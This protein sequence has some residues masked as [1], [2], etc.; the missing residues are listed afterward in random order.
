MSDLENT[1]EIQINLIKELKGIESVILMQRG[2]IPIHSSGKWFSIN[3][4]NVLSSVSSLVFNTGIKLH[5]QELKYI[6]I[7]SRY[8]KIL[9]APL[10]SPIEPFLIKNVNFHGINDH[11]HEFFILI[12]AQ[13][14]INLGGIFLQTSECLRK[15]KIHLFTSGESYREESNPKHQSLDE[16]SNYISSI[17]IPEM[18]SAEFNKILETIS[19]TIPDLN[20]AL[21]SINGFLASH[22]LK[23]I[24]MTN[25][26]LTKTSQWSYTIFQAANR[27]AELL[28]KKE[29]NSILLDCQSTFQFVDGLENAVFTTK[30]GKHRQK[31]GLIRLI[32]PQ[33]KKKIG[34]LINKLKE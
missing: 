19:R 14:D 8:A 5:P 9:I 30:I 12:V 27:C 7:E 24:S 1:I 22:L 4:I 13:P 11:K 32:L 25:E 16:Y 28:G 18:V 3:E 6:L 17:E 31:F 34:D 33:F 26:E 2:G 20:Y 15:I 10:N 21:V 23:G 29:A